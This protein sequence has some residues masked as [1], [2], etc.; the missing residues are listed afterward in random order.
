MNV[1]VNIFS[2]YSEIF[3]NTRQI[4]VPEIIQIIVS[5]G[6]LD[7]KKAALANKYTEAGNK[8]NRLQASQIGVL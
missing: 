2:R 7:L 3:F 8:F 6:K 4:D 1:E 5:P